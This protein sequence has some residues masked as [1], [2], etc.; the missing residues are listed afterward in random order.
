M[1]KMIVMDPYC[2]GAKRRCTKRKSRE[3]MMTARAKMQVGHEANELS[4]IVLLL[5]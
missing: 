3:E 4:Q 5:A 2:G 1:R